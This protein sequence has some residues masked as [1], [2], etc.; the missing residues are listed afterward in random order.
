ME[1]DAEQA[2]A[3]A[4]ANLLHVQLDDVDEAILDERLRVCARS[5][6][7]HGDDDVTSADDPQTALVAQLTELLGGGDGLGRASY[8]ARILASPDLGPARVEGVAATR[9]KKVRAEPASQAYET[10][11]VSHVGYF[12][13]LEGEM[14]TWQEGQDSPNRLD[15]LVWLWTYLAVGSAPGKVATGAD[16]GARIP[17]GAAAVTRPR[18]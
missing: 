2:H 4:D 1:A 17:T 15:A 18:R 13:A 10:G 14:V 11:Q 9:S 16:T 7:G 8:A 12:P 6:S 5:L 3:L